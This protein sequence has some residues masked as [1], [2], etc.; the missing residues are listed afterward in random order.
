VAEKIPIEVPEGMTPEKLLELVKQY[1]ARRVSGE[2]QR[3][4]RSW[5]VKK[6]IENHK[7]E[8]ESLREQA[9]KMK[10]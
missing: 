3:K 5:A 8:Y 9:K 6:L 1:E 2:A 7:D 10:L 4:A